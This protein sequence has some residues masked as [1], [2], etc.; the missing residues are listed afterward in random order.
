MHLESERAG[1]HPV[2]HL[3]SV[4]SSHLARVVA[5]E[6][7]FWPPEP[8]AFSPW[9]T[10]HIQQL[11]CN[12]SEDDSEQRFV[13]AMNR[14]YWTS[15]VDIRPCND[16]PCQQLTSYHGVTLPYGRSTN[17][18]WESP[19]IWEFLPDFT[20]IFSQFLAPDWVRHTPCLGI[21]AT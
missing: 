2:G 20:E 17:K 9:L 21:F 14:Q 3:I 7:S 6:Y 13:V 11:G 5:A 4:K 18:K 8:L 16:H 19:H 10:I 1:V 15:K 12:V